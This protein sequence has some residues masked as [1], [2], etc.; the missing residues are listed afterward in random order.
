MSPSGIKVD[1]EQYGG[2]CAPA[3]YYNKKENNM[4]FMARGIALALAVVAIAVS[5]QGCP[6]VPK[7]GGFTASHAESK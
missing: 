3:Y 7:S 6:R 2:A 5:A 4:S 1:S